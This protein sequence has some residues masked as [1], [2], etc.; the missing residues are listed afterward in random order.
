MGRI[1]PIGMPEIILILVLVVLLFGGR[2]LPALAKGIA[3]AIR[4][5]RSN[6]KDVREQD[7]DPSGNDAVQASQA[8][9]RS[10]ATPEVGTNRTG[11][12]SHGTQ[13]DDAG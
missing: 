6:I 9:P 1:G 13:R 8:T 5:F 10:A 7:P 11:A 2:R 4:E 3:Q 12:A